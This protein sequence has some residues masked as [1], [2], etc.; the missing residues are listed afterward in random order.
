MKSLSVKSWSTTTKIIVAV[1]LFVL[2][3]SLL[4]VIP[5]AITPDDDGGSDET[6]TTSTTTTTTTTTT[7]PETLQRDVIFN[8]DSEYFIN[9]IPNNALLE[10]WQVVNAVIEI[11][12]EI[13]T[14]IELGQTKTITVLD[15]HNYLTGVYLNFSFRYDGVNYTVMYLDTFWYV[16]IGTNNIEFDLRVVNIFMFENYNVTTERWEWI[17]IDSFNW[18]GYV[19]NGSGPEIF[20]DS[21]YNWLP[22]EPLSSFIVDGGSIAGYNTVI[23]IGVMIVT[24]TVLHRK[25][26]RRGLK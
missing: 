11:N 15:E 8:W 24:V 2:V 21:N 1:G 5:L 20:Q 26:Y 18:G 9:F 6:T 19:H 16:D 3:V 12:D 7:E 25:V 14:T 22:Y 4:V 17:G 13:N 23:V 10:G